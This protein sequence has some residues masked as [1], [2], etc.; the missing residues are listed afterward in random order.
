[1]DHTSGWTDAEGHRFL[2]CQPYGLRDPESLAQA[3]KEFELD[4]RVS[5]TGWYGWGTV[6][7][8]LA[9]RAQKGLRLWSA[10]EVCEHAGRLAAKNGRTELPPTDPH[11]AL[12]WWQRG[13]DR[14]SRGVY[15]PEPDARDARQKTQSKAK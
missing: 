13:F 12:A 7:I 15:G 1:M 9:P 10:A 6:C 14:Q 11:E 5:S 2:L 3:C 4:C 8:S